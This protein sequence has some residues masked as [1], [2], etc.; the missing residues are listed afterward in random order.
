MIIGVLRQLSKTEVVETGKP[1]V[2]RG[3]FLLIALLLLTGFPIFMSITG[4][5]GHEE[6]TFSIYNDDWDGCSEFG[7]Y[8][9]E[10]YGGEDGENIQIITSSLTMLNRVNRTGILIMMGPTIGYGFTETIAIV[11]WIIGGGS[12]LLVN[13]FGSANDIL[14][15]FTSLMKLAALQFSGQE[16]IPVLGLKFNTSGVLLDVGSYDTNPAMPVI[17][18]FSDEFG[19]ITSGV[20]KIICNYPSIISMYYKSGEDEDGDPIY[21]W[22]PVPYGAASSTTT[23]WIETDVDAVKRGD[24]DNIKPDGGEWGPPYFSYNYSGISVSGYLGFSIALPLPLGDEGKF[25]LVSDPDI[26]ANAAWENA[27]YDNQRFAKNIIDWMM[28][29]YSSDD[30]PVIIFDEGHITQKPYSSMLYFGAY[31]RTI[32][33]YTAFSLSPA[34]FGVDYRNPSEGN[35]SAYLWVNVFLALFFPLIVM[36]VGSRWIPKKRAPRPLLMTRLKRYYARSYFAVKMR[37]FLQFKQY[38]RATALIYRR[39][40]RTLIKKLHYRG[41]LD[42]KTLTDLISKE[43]TKFSKEQI[44]QRLVLAENVS[45]GAVTLDE[46]K[47]LKLFLALKELIGELGG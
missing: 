6:A 10:Q 32:T 16:D 17:T 13:D 41:P 35:L 26:F 28:S 43:V 24:W 19:D 34:L 39:L 12:I 14:D 29:G 9:K 3:L 23:A 47:F 40:K 44:M 8:V 2:S 46:E 36:M 45:K 1:G 25:M 38:E 4:I 37:Y 30:N 27:E 20:D 31:L 21:K 5:S 18:E 7:N 15:L 33:Q 42:P 22:Y 11:D